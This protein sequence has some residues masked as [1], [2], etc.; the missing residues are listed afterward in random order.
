MIPCWT[1]DFETMPIG[2]RPHH[3]PPVPTS[4][5]IR[6][7]DGPTTFF[8]WGHPSGNNCD[9]VDAQ[10]AFQTAVDSGLPL[11]F[12]HA[13]FDIEVAMDHFGIER[14]PWHRI[15]DTMFLAFLLN[16]YAR[17]LGLKELAVDW[18]GANPDEQDAVHEWVL[19]HK[20]DLP[21][22]EF[23]LNSKKEPYGQ[24]SKRNAGAWIGFVP[25]EIV[26]PYANGDVDRTFAL[27][28]IMY[29]AVM[30]SDMGEAYDIERELMPYLMDN[31][32][33]G[34]PIDVERLEREIAEYEYW[35]DMV[36]Q[37]LRWRL[38]APDLNFGA[39][40][41]LA[42]ILDTRGI[43]DNFPKTKTGRRST[44]KDALHPDM[45]NDPQVASA[46]GYRNR[47]K[48]C[49]DTFMR[50]WLKQAKA[51]PGR[52]STS[53]NQVSSDMGGTRTGRPSTSNHNLLNIT[54]NFDKAGDGY[55]HPDF[56]TGLPHLPLVRRYVLPEEGHVINGRDFSGQELRIFGHYEHGDLQQRYAADPKLDVH[57]YV[58]QTIADL[59]GDPFWATQEA[60]E[61]RVKTLNFQAIY[62]G[63]TTAAKDKLRCSYAEA[64]RY[65]AFHDSALP[66]R[67]ILADQ[68]SMIVRAGGAVKTYGGRRYVRPPMKQQK[69][70][71]WGDSDYILINYLVQGSAA[72]ITKRA[73]LRIFK[74]PEYNSVFMVQ[75]YDEIVLSSP[76]EDADR[77][78]LVMKRGMEGIPLRI[79]LLTDAE[80]GPNW[81]EMEDRKDL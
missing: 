31:E 70:G 37:W 13:K 75:V 14:P 2:P 56:L 9:Q 68:L 48:T 80:Q 5:S 17:K 57:S 58:G 54:K 73:M 8:C 25:G 41:D 20:K 67:R 40:E 34:L 10:A 7:P 26:G 81:G 43:V 42:E 39:K 76:I 38:D 74:D 22:F 79:P 12:H 18:L 15:H 55:V 36:E 60:R 32:R 6:P 53:W 50:P 28:Q 72:D 77:Q 21:R 27:F 45:F 61:K 59:T 29:P 44:S 69:N 52:I 65:K 51:W 4:M 78:S 23:I 3:Y 47:L 71:R 63:G 1:I 49:L 66:G 16:P 46:L 11:V 64:Q 30:E 19:A 24:P 35:F 33:R 62:G